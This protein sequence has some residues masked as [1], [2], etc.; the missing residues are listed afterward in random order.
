MPLRG[1][2]P[3]PEQKWVQQIEH[4]ISIRMTL[5]CLLPKPTSSR[6]LMV[7]TQSVVYRSIPTSNRNILSLFL[8][9]LALYIVPHHLVHGASVYLY[10]SCTVHQMVYEPS[11]LSNRQNCLGIEGLMLIGKYIPQ[12]VGDTFCPADHQV[13][14]IVRMAIYPVVRL[15]KI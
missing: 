15:S 14:V 3:I 10:M 8:F 9:M 5:R 1:T 12:L 6:L 4:L 11:V 7:I 13:L 2:Y